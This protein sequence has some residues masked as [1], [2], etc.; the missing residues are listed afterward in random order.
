MAFLQSAINQVGR[1]L[2]RVV[3]NTVFKDSH[4]IPIRRAASYQKKNKQTSNRVKA[5]KANPIE[6]VQSRFQQSINFKTGYTPNTLISK[7]G[8]AFIVIKNEAK[9]F[10]DDGYLSQNESQKL[11]KMLTQFNDKINDVEDILSFTHEDNTKVYEQLE[12]IVEATKEVMAETLEISAQACV[13]RA[14]EY[15]QVSKTNELISFKRYLALHL[16]W[17]S[18]YAKGDQK[19]VTNAVIANILDIVTLTFP[20]TRTAL[21]IMGLTSYSRFKKEHEETIEGLSTLA[22]QER[23]RAKTYNKFIM[24]N[25]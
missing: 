19:N 6:S 10:I 20:L 7:L 5:R 17:M 3:S 14:I 4:S 2:G 11:F 23:E 13:A 21:F 1:D 16:I 9:T 8:G 25:S 18:N 15:E 22:Y 12:R 24:K